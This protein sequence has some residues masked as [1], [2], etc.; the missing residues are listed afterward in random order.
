MT[1]YVTADNLTPRRPPRCF[2]NI[3]G[4]DLLSDPA[5][6][7]HGWIPVTE[8]RPEYDPAAQ[9]LT[10][11]TVEIV[12][13]TA[14]ATYTAVDIPLEEIKAAKRT[15]SLAAQDARLAQGM[16][17]SIGLKVCCETSD[18]LMFNAGYSGM[19]VVNATTDYIWDFNRVPHEIT[20]EQYAVLGAELR[21]HVMTI[22]LTTSTLLALIEEAEDAATVL[23]VTYA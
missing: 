1:L 22:R 23:A 5:K 2:G 11:P 15:E 20:A 13:D 14:T 19:T 18:V 7:L 9:R 8:I 3:S 10:G 21:T 6:L 17:S 12:G 16:V 4:F